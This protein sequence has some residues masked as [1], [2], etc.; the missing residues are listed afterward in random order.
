ML[1]GSGGMF[2]RE[3]FYKTLCNAFLRDFTHFF[4][5]QILFLIW[6]SEETT[7]KG[8]LSLSAGPLPMAFQE[9]V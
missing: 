6:E 2:P 4:Y 3:N 9:S 8:N 5:L 7:L 1:V